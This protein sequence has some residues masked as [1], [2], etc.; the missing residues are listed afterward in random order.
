MTVRVRLAPSPTGNLHIGTARTAVFN[1]LYSHRHDGQFI[2]RIEDTDQDRSKPEFTRNILA[3]LAWLGLDW[4]EGPLYQSNRM[5]RYREVVQQLLDQNLAY[6]CFCTE[7]ELEAMRTAQKA[8]GKAP[9]YD[10]R[11][12]DL[13]P[14]QQQAFREEG[15][16]P[17]IRFKIA[18][19]LDISWVD[20]IRGSIT[21][22]TTDLGGDMVIARAG[23]QPLYNLAVVVD[24]IDMA[25]THVLRGEDHIGNTPKQILLY[26]ALGYEPPAFAHSPL[27]LNPEGRK[28]SKRDGA[29]SVFEFQQMGYLPDALKNYLALLSWSPPDNEELFSLDKAATQFSFERVTHSAARFDWDKLNWINSQ[30]IRQL[31]PGDLVRQLSPFWQSAGLDITTVPSA[32]WLEQMARLISEGIHR[33][34]EAPKISRYLLDEKLVYSIPALEQLRLDGV[35][36]AM[37]GVAEAL[38]QAELPDISVETLKPVVDQVAKAQGLKKGLVMKS[39]RAALTGDL[40]GP[41][42]MESFVLL[43]QRGWALDRLKAVEVV[44]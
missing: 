39:L 29:T 7:A 19:P 13:T 26:R 38:A 11:H 22:N 14:E 8:A 3:G 36:A 40:Q 44:G 35:K 28:L 5:D 18:E 4:E 32:E 43:H 21:W 15:R 31:T 37:Q 34:T 1:W 42:L 2:L 6:Y 23:G 25:I 27:I 30:Y 24:D 12:R 9:R 10:N 41:D 16:Q 20:L 33:L 17:V